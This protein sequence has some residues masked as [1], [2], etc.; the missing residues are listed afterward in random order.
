VNYH[1]LGVNYHALG[2]NYHALGVKQ[3]T[4]L[5]QSFRRIGYV[6]GANYHVLG[7]NYHKRRIL[8]PNYHKFDFV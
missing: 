2:V 3:K 6:L 1:A 4:A 7:V 8:W 5:N